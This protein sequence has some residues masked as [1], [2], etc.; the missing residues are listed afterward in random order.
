MSGEFETIFQDPQSAGV[1]RF[2]LRG[3]AT[4]MTIA[5]R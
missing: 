3:V 5:L 1:A 4:L 2:F